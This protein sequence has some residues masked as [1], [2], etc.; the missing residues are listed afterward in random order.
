M[1]RSIGPSKPETTA[2]S[3]L[4]LDSFQSMSEP[5]SAPSASAALSRMTRRVSFQL[6]V[7]EIDWLTE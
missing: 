2:V 5:R 1:R 6:L 4:P 3:S 7:N